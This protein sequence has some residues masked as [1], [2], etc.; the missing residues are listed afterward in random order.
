V[1][2]AGDQSRPEC[3]PD[4]EGIGGLRFWPRINNKNTFP[5]PHRGIIQNSQSKELSAHGAI[6]AKVI[7]A[8][9]P[10]H[11]FDGLIAL[12]RNMN[13]AR[14]LPTSGPH[15]ERAQRWRCANLMSQA[16]QEPTPGPE[17]HPTPF[18]GPVAQAALFLSPARS[19]A[20]LLRLRWFRA[21]RQPDLFGRMLIKRLRNGAVVIGMVA[22]ENNRKKTRLNMKSFTC[23]D[24]PVAGL[25]LPRSS[26]AG[27]MH[28]CLPVRNS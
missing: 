14:H 24:G 4:D 19:N 25:L 8:L 27:S 9:L 22:S 18:E 15:N 2:A 3:Q 6:E 17:S 23:S 1:A 10:F 26:L 5:T 12:G 7:F 16:P 20:G 13:C 28:R 11:G 21:V